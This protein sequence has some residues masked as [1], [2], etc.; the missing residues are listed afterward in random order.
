MFA[1]GPRYK[2]TLQYLSC[3]QDW[4][5]ERSTEDIVLFS[6]PSTSSGRFI[7]VQETKILSYIPPSKI[8]SVRSSGAARVRSGE[9]NA[10][11][12]WIISEL[13]TDAIAN[14]SFMETNVVFVQPPRHHDAGSLCSLL[15]TDRDW[16]VLE[17]FLFLLVWLLFHV[18]L[19]REIYLNFTVQ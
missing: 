18:T 19:H 10:V 5:V 16:M 4:A 15:Q 14:Y 9:V 8:L 6:P 11:S 13:D 17:S 1:I 2:E 12:T 3:H 7:R